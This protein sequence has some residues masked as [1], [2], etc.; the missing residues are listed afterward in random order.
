M[1]SAERVTDTIPNA[2]YR[3]AIAKDQFLNIVYIFMFKK[4][5]TTSPKHNPYV[6]TWA[7][8]G[9]VPTVFGSCTPIADVTNTSDKKYA[10]HIYINFLSYG[11]AVYCTRRLFPMR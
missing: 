11:E 6:T 9:F 10:I 8:A 7:V 2:V 1:N 3:K 4:P 5:Y